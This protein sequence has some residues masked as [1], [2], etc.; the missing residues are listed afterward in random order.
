[1]PGRSR[2]ASCLLILGGSPVQ[3]HHGVRANRKCHRSP[4]NTVPSLFWT[5][6]REKLGQFERWPGCKLSTKAGGRCGV[7]VP[8][9]VRTCETKEGEVCKPLS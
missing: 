1:M 3:A 4:C 9:P 5:L 6:E 2:E 7:A 8:W